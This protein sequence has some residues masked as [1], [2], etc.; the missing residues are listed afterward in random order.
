MKIAL[1]VATVLS[2]FNIIFWGMFVAFGLLVSLVT[3]QMALVASLVLLSAIPLNCFAA[4]RLHNSIRYS[5]APLSH[6]TPIGIRF[7]GFIAL[8]IG[9]TNIAT[10]FSLITNPGPVLDSVK[11]V[12]AKFAEQIPENL[13]QFYVITKGEIVFFGACSVVL[14]LMVAVNVVLNLRL[15]RWYYLVH[16][17]DIS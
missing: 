7:V 11:E 14:G 16:R 15:L 1:K 17:S 6:Q 8:F 9:I 12:V 4:L 5:G 10:G 3:G 13:R 2:W